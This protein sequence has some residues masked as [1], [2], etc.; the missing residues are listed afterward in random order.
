[1]EH[2]PQLSLPCVLHWDLDHFVVLRQVGPKGIT[3]HDPARGIRK[4][5]LAEASKSFTGIALE[6]A[7]AADFKTAEQKQSISLRGL[8][9]NVRG[10]GS[11]LIRIFLLAIALEVFGIVSPFYLQ[12]VI[13]QVLVSADRSLLTLLGIGF[14]LVTLFSSVITSIRAWVVLYISTLLSVQWAANVFSHLM[15]L[16]LDWFEKRHVGDVVSRYGAVNN[17]QQAITT[18]LVAAV[19]DGIMAFATLVVIAIY[20]VELTLIVVGIFLLYAIVRWVAFQP[21]KRATEDRIVFAAKQ[22]TQLLESIRGVQTL[23]LF[24][25]QDE[26]TAR[27]SNALVETANR[28][29]VVQRLTIIFGLLQ[30]ILAGTEKVV[31]V[32][33]AALMVIHGTFTVGMLI[34]FSMY[35]TQFTS[36]ADGLI[37][38]WIDLKMLRLYGERLA[39]IVLTPPEKHLESF[40]EGPVPESTIELRDVSFRYADGEPWILRHCS[41]TVEA[42]QALAIIGPSGAGKTTLAKL[43]LGLLEPTEG[44]VLFGGLDIKKLGLKAYR[45]MVAAVMQDDQLFAGSIADNISLFA[46]DATNGTIEEA[47]R[48][49][50]IHDEIAAMPMGY[51][52]LVGDMGSTL[53]GG[54][55]QRVVLARALYRNPQFIVLDEAT[56][57][58]DIARE[59][60]VA[61]AIAHLAITRI[62]IAHRPETIAR[63]DAICLLID[64]QARLVDRE[65]FWRPRAGD[66]DAATADRGTIQTED[67]EHA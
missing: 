25:L 19:L 52:S 5:T 32:W 59:R 40:Y 64:G 61:D 47:G 42:G 14:L 10:L 26:R 15:R 27:Y 46:P 36:R 17:I 33:L 57:H 8:S 43:V 6:L 4:L 58:L 53:S 7:P 2:L 1:M 18:N 54:Q 12:W 49:A 16:P 3:I 23:K 67:F 29:V 62:I 30:H 56:S 22:Q 31:L 63:A 51:R 37:I 66:A 55:K 65:D 28:E 39:D 11:A 20:S 60:Q 21:F 35:A 38:A 24:N 34:A 45:S 41:L 9:G 13:D 50:G 44:E 48:A